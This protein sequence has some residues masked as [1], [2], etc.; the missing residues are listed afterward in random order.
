MNFARKVWKLLVGIKDGL[1]LLF[2]LVFFIALFGILNA[3]PDSAAVRDGALLL[4]LDGVVVEERS[5]IDPV[6]ALLSGAAPVGEYPVRD[7]VHALDT[8]AKDDRIDAVVLDLSTFLGGGQVHLT[9]IGAALER[10]KQADKPVLSY[11]IAY[12][13]DG[14]M[15]AAHASEAWVDPLGGAI[16]AGP[17]GERLYYAGLIDRLRI[18]ARVY[19]V[20]TYKSAVEPFLASEMS[21]AARENANALYGALWEEWQ[22][23]VKK[24]RPDADFDRVIADPAGWVEASAGDLAKAA[25][26][27]GLVDRIGTRTKFGERVAE[28]TGEDLWDET[29]GAYPS[30]DLDVWLEANPRETP[31][32]PIGVITIAGE[33]VDGE[34]GP[35]TAGGIR[36]ADLL[37][38]TLAA[39]ELKALV[40][41]VDSPGGS[42]TASEDIRQAI[43]R[44]REAGIPVAVSMANVAA[45]GGYWVSMPA[46]RIFAEPETITGSIGI[47]G[48]VPTFE[49]TLAEIGVTTDGVKTT[50][51]SGQPDI[52]AGFSPEIDRILQS[53]I[54][55]NYARFLTLV[56]RS[57]NMS[58]ARVDAVAQGRVWDGGSAR[59]LGLVDQFGGID[60]AVAWAAAEA[61]LEDGDWHTRYLESEPDGFAAFFS[62]MFAGDSA[63]SSA[64]RDV[65]GL[66]AAR[67][68]I[69]FA[70]IEADVDRLLAAKGA[71]A[72]CMEC[73]HTPRTSSNTPVD[74][75]WLA[76]LTGLFAN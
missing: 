16:V 55:N 75:T 23:T 60:A 21:P 27:A 46:Q 10:V 33:I 9:E 4:A 30:S 8:A 31:G 67:Q 69:Q 11:A 22:A 45:S 1:V 28:I 39:G 24:A 59:Q 58:V 40:V 12:A 70:T 2:M 66:I 71:Q 20:G 52:L 74:S 32:S 53:T 65:F 49:D 38:E 51:L 29:P 19:R 73:P 63:A 6:G 64:P 50:P 35:G 57:R 68:Q 41:R 13:D 43:N 18:N 5:L 76:R 7:I 44:Y 72:L 14:M 3:R 17:G 34:A 26:N 62:D 25:L 36:I 54:E 61:G 15:L 42:V 47:F 56:A 37:D 48:V